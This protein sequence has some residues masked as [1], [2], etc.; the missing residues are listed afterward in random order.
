MVDHYVFAMR[1]FA[2]ICALFIPLLII[3]CATRENQPTAAETALEKYDQRGW[4]SEE[5]RIR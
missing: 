1:L 4:N 5:G 2:T 3:G